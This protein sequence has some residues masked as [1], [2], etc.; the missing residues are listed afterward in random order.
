[1]KNYKV[2]AQSNN[3]AKI[4]FKIHQNL[5]EKIKTQYQPKDIYNFDKTA[6]NWGWLFE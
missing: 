2:F 6:S 3:F 4:S 5:L 1:M